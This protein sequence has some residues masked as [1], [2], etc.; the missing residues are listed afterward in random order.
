[1]GIH[2]QRLQ[3]RLS[4]GS[5]SGGGE[6]SAV[7]GDSRHSRWKPQSR[8]AQ[9]QRQRFRPLTALEFRAAMTRATFTCWRTHMLAAARRPALASLRWLRNHATNARATAPQPG[10]CRCL[11]VRLDSRFTRSITCN[12]QQMCRLC[13]ACVRVECAD[14]TRIEMPSRYASKQDEMRRVCAVR[15]VVL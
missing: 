4:V 1:M 5:S 11:V 15:Y 13:T 8:Q 10:Q 9:W 3:D 12:R 6:S 14:T 7:P 2:L